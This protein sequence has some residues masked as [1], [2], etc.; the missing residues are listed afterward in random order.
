MALE[1][2]KEDIVSSAKTAVDAIS[3]DS[4]AEIAKI[5][6]EAEAAIADMKKKEEKRLTEALDRLDRQEIS[7]AELESKKIVLAK[8]KEILEKAFDETLAE[9]EAAPA[10]VKK[11]QY[12]KMVEAA[13]KVIKEPKA[14]CSKGETLKAEDLGVVSLTK[15][16][17]ITGGL[18]F[19]SKDGTIQ[20]DMQF[21]TI[22]ETVWDRE[23]KSISDIL[24][25]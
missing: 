24:F 5:K 23:S 25:G 15:L 16:D 3:K 9:L 19:E 2:V 1:N 10:K 13:K 22:L 11:A 21:R 14:F 20:V 6:A 17:S 7:S 8:K 12:V 4:K 18:I